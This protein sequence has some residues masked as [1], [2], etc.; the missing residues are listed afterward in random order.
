MSMFAEKLTDSQLCLYT[1]HTEPQTE[2]SGRSNV[3]K[4][5]HRRTT[6]TVVPILYN[7]PPIPSLKV[8]R[9]VGV[10]DPF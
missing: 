10:L 1:V 4:S 5:P 9:C 7:G 2:T 8:A 6:W 3:T